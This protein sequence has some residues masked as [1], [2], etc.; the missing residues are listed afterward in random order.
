MLLPV[1]VTQIEVWDAA[2]SLFAH[3]VRR[4]EIPL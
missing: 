3:P 1:V 4:A 2:G